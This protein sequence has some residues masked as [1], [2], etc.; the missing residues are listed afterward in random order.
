[1]K[2]TRLEDVLAALE[3]EQYEIQV[4][5]EIARKAKISIDR[6]LELS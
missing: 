5:Q 4:P 6:M 1:M 3:H 2:K